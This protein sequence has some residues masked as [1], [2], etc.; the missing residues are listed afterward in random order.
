MIKKL[1]LY[2]LKKH[3]T[4]EVKAHESN[5]REGIRKGFKVIISFA[6]EEVAEDWFINRETK[7]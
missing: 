4:V 7:F 2:M 6:G 3:L 5:S 1:F